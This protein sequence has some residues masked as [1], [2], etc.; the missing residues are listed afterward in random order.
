[1]VKIT[2]PFTHLPSGNGL[3]LITHPTAI[4]TPLSI[5]NDLHQS[6]FFI[7]VSKWSSISTHELGVEIVMLGVEEGLR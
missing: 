7:S 6:C 4:E 2:P 3:Y 5:T 1:M